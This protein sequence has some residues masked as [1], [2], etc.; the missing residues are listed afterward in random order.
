MVLF[1]RAD[2]SDDLVVNPIRNAHETTNTEMMKYDMK[3][4]AKTM[5]NNLKRILALLTAAILLLALPVADALAWHEEGAVAKTGI[6]ENEEYYGYNAEADFMHA[7]ANGGAYFGATVMRTQDGKEVAGYGMNVGADAKVQGGRVAC[8]MRAGTEDY[9]T[10]GGANA[11]V[12]TA[13]A[14]ANLNVGM[15]NGEFVAKGTLGAEAN[16]AEANLKGGVTIGGVDVNAGVGVKV[17]IGL[18]AQAGYM[19]GHFKAELTAVAGVGFNV[20]VDIDVGALCE[21]A[22]D[23]AEWVAKETAKQGIKTT[24]KVV[25]KVVRFWKWLTD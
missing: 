16:V 7:D 13:N 10:H 25:D 11:A 1:R 17:G 21:K 12:G 15:Y 5:K 6:Q 2:H 19:D 18:K 3:G 23:G 9:N 4:R 22:K 14:T 24:V 8:D 20:N